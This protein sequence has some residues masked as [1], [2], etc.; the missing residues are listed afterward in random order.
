MIRLPGRDDAHAGSWGLGIGYLLVPCKTIR[1]CRARVKALVEG[2]LG[3]ADRS[4]DTEVLVIGP[5][6]AVEAVL[7]LG[8]AWARARKMRAA[9]AADNLRA[10][11]K[12]RTAATNGGQNRKTEPGTTPAPPRPAVGQNHPRLAT[13]IAAAG[14][15]SRGVRP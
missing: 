9:G 1:T 5:D 4:G 15:I 13:V 10:F 14:G 12:P 6:S 3:L 2:W 11:R 8:P 7:M